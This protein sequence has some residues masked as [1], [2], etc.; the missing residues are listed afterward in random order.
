MRW[1]LR[2]NTAR[3][4]DATRVA[5]PGEPLQAKLDDEWRLMRFMVW[6]TSEKEDPVAVDTA[7]GYASTVQGWLA[8][9]FGVKIGAGI[10][11]HRVA[12][13]VKGL[14]RARGGKPP[15]RLRKA[16]TPEKLARAFLLLDP[17]CPLHANV[18]AMLALMLQALL[19]AGEAVLSDKAAQWTAG[20]HLS[21]DDFIVGGRAMQVTIAPEKDD[22]SLGAKATPVIVGRGGVFVDAVW[23]FENLRRVDP[24]APRQRPFTPA[25]RD[26]AT[27]RALRV[28]DANKWVK[29]L[30]QSIGEDPDEYGSHSCRTGGAT[31]MFKAGASALDIRTIGRW[32]S[33]VYL[34]YVHADCERAVEMSRRLA[35]T[36]CSPAEDPFIE[37][38]F[39]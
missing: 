31:A 10:A 22:N 33:D 5:G 39:Y 29:R 36:Q 30:M 7:R 14:H 28:A 25:F 19:R 1:W 12:Q 9:N 11:L 8:R 24:V 23:E 37:V 4:E 3:G 6:L 34:I 32:S 15:K 16:L 17:E 21:R 38:E 2:F 26:P 13:L 20:K 18:R 27:G 35:S